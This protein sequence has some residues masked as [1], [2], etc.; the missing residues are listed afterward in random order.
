M[1]EVG[2][3]CTTEIAVQVIFLCLYTFQHIFQTVVLILVPCA[4]QLNKWNST[5]KQLLWKC[6]WWLR[7]F[8]TPRGRIRNM[9]QTTLNFNYFKTRARWILKYYYAI[10]LPDIVVIHFFSQV[11]VFSELDR[12]AFGVPGVVCSQVSVLLF[13]DARLDT[14]RAA[15][16]TSKTLHSL[17]RSL[18][19]NWSTFSWNK[20]KMF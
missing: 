2:K 4:I 1:L 15:V 14:S 10:E 5:E 7:S 12:T 20:N 11:S 19:S 16:R 18:L 8:K 17:S 9:S 6:I 3:T 13:V